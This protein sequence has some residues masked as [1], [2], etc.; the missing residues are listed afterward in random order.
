MSTTTADGILEGSWSIK[1]IFNRI[2]NFAKEHPLLSLAFSIAVGGIGANLL[3][4]LTFM[5]V[6]HDMLNIKAQAAILWSQQWT[7][8]VPYHLGLT[9]DDGGLLSGFTDWLFA[10]QIEALESS[11][12]LIDND[13]ILPDLELGDI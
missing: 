11:N 9:M 6:I 1:G 10:D 2:S 13:D 12:Q 7:S 3:W 8:F 4:D 5:P